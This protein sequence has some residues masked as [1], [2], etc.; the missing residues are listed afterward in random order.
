MPRLP[1]SAPRVASPSTRLQAGKPLKTKEKSRGVWTASS[2]KVAGRIP[3]GAQGNRPS[4]RM[5]RRRGGKLQPKEAKSHLEYARSV[6]EA[7][8]S[9][10]LSLRSRLGS[11][12]AAALELMLACPGHV[13]VTGIGKPG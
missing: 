5:G 12:F 8:A 3:A 2:T 10:I 9:A 13:V 1:R 4:A 7:E 11:S 6:L